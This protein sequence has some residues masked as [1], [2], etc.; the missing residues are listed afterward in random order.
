MTLIGTIHI[1][2]NVTNTFQ[3]SD[4]KCNWMIISESNTTTARLFVCTGNYNWKSYD[5]TNTKFNIPN[6]GANIG[7]NYLQTC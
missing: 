3:L 1:I 5:V 7:I 4:N 2:Q 6:F